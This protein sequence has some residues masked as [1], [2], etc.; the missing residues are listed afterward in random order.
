MLSE[1]PLLIQNPDPAAIVS[2]LTADGWTKTDPN[3]YCN[4][5]K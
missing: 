1:L 2:A 3:K 5:L 4:Q